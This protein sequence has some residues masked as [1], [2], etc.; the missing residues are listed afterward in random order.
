MTLDLRTKIRAIPDFPKAG[1]LFRDVT[2]LLA[3]PEALAF[4]VAELVR[5]FADGRVDAVAG[6]DARGFIFGALAARELAAG[7]VPIRKAGKLPYRTLS[8]SYALEYG[9]GTLEMHADAVATGTR[10]LI[11]DDLIATGGTASATCA[12]VERGGGDVVGLSFVIE[13][14]ALGGRGKLT[15]RAVHA[16]VGY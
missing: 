5:P 1:I 2:P 12:L 3:D 9:H 15:G 8:E 10:V 6:I 16:L 13:L 4:A 11:V 7:F 14:E